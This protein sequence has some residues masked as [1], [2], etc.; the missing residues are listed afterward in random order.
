VSATTDRLIDLM[1]EALDHAI[2]IDR[3]DVGAGSI[4]RLGVDSVAMLAFMVAVEDV[5]GF[6]WEDDLAPETL[7][8]FGALADYVDARA[9]A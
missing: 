9:L 6:E 5:F 3:V 4:R 8:S 7:A 1:E 2:A